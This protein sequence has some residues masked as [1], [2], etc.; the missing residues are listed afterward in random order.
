MPEILEQKQGYVDLGT[1]E[2]CLRNS[3]SVWLSLGGQGRAF[4]RPVGIM[5]TK[6]GGHLVIFFLRMGIQHLVGYKTISLA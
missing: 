6:G 1:D 2:L 4:I 3:L 5:N